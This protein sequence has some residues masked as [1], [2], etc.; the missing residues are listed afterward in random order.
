MLDPENSYKQLKPYDQSSLK[1]LRQQNHPHDQ[2]DQK[3]ELPSANEELAEQLMNKLIVLVFIG[4]FIGL[5]FFGDMLTLV[6][7]GISPFHQPLL[8]NNQYAQMIWWACSAIAGA[9]FLFFLFLA[10][11]LPLTHRQVSPAP[12]WLGSCVGMS[13]LVFLLAG[14]PSMLLAGVLSTPEADMT[15]SGFVQS[16]VSVNIGASVTFVNPTDGV[17]QLLCIGTHQR[18]DSDPGNYNQPSQL[19]H[20]LR[21]LPGQSVSIVFGAFGDYHVTSQTTANM[22][23]TISASDSGRGGGG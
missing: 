21:V 10:F 18:C 20:G 3:N 1:E 19:Y 22:N 15:R 13:I 7:R 11:G 12:G 5:I 4:L 6:Q 9:S 23:I 16:D 17:P 8:P 2:D 14:F